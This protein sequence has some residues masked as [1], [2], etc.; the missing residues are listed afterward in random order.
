M[1]FWLYA[2]PIS[3]EACLLGDRLSH[4]LAAQLAETPQEADMIVILGGDGTMLRAVR[5]P[6]T[7]GKPFWGINCGHLGYL[8][9]CDKEKAPQV[10]ESILQGAF[11]LEYR[12]RIGGTLSDG[13]PLSA[14]NELLLHRGVCVHTLLI[15]VHVNGNLAL[16]YRGDGLIVCTPSG[17]TAYNLSAGGPVLLP[18][19][20]ALVLTPI[21][22]QALSA[23]PLVVSAHDTVRVSWQ[24]N[25]REG[26][27]MQPDLTADGIEKY[28]L[29]GQGA[30]EIGGP[31]QRVALVRT[32]D[33][34]FYQRLQHRMHWD[35][36]K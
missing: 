35:A 26:E 28:L 31:V 1:R 5:I 14:L 25:Q 6:G 12:V 16:R 18:E 15:Q 4:I 17:S 22:P 36:E 10:L 23:V 2:N 29:P 21:C 33:A 7:E 24:M 8:T 3:S 13:Q 30:L 32:Q 11:R 34:C 19:M 9:D 27:G 20:D